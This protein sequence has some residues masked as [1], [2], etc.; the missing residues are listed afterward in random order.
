MKRTEPY[1]PH[2]YRLEPGDGPNMPP[3][4]GDL[5]AAEEQVSKILLVHFKDKSL[6]ENKRPNKAQLTHKGKVVAQLIVTPAK[7]VERL[8]VREVPDT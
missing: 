6:P 4:S 1:I 2:I 8:E 7:K 5:A 3:I